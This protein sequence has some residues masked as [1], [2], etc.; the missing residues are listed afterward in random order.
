MLLLISSLH[1]NGPMQRRD[2]ALQAAAAAS[3]AMSMDRR[4][5]GSRDVEEG[6]TGRHK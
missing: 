1:L 2:T 3:G 6:G 5:L 4:S